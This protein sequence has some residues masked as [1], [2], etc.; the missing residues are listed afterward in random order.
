MNAGLAI[1]Q[2]GLARGELLAVDDETNWI[3]DLYKL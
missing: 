3:K 2:N 1:N